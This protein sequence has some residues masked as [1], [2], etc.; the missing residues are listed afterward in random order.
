MLTLDVREGEY[1]Y[2]GEDIRICLVKRQGPNNYI[3]IEA[4]KDIKIL[5]EKVKQKIDSETSEQVRSKLHSFFSDAFA[6]ERA[7]L[8]IYIQITKK[9]SRMMTKK[10]ME[11]FYY[12]YGSKNKH[13]VH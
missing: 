10:F 2:I 4:P 6:A 8:K 13:N 7:P 1:I 12:G 11:V 3:G 9:S 5:R